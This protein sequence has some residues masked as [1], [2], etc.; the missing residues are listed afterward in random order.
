MHPLAYAIPLT[1][2]LLPTPLFSAIVYQCEDNDGSITFTHLGCSTDQT[3]QLRALDLPPSESSTTSVITDTKQAAAK[4]KRKTKDTEEQAHAVTGIGQRQDG[5][6]N[7]VSASMRRKAMI[8]KEVRPGMTRADVESMLGRPDA[9]SSTNGRVRYNYVD[10][11]DKGRKRSV[12]FD[13]EG[14]VTGKP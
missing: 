3:Q 8:D 11:R 13:E 2:L 1:L 9:V 14:C 7:K 5:C 6:G 12:S 10:K 4:P